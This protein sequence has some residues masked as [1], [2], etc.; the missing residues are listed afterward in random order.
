M[1]TPL[2]E[3]RAHSY[4]V[5]MAGG[6]GTRLWPLSRKAKPKQ[7]QAFTGERTMIQETFERI[8]RV[9][10]RENI[11]VS[12]TK[13]YQSMVLEQLPEM[14]EQRL[15]LEPEARNTAPAIALAAAL[16]ALIDQEAIIATIASD[17]AIE[18]PEEF[19]AVITAGLA[20][21]AKHRDTLITI[22]INPTHPDTS[23]GYIKMGEELTT[24]S[25]K[26]VFVVDAFKEKPDAKTAE[27]YLADWEYLWNAG[28]FVFSA[29]HFSR[30]TEQHSPELHQAIT[31][32][33]ARKKTNTLDVETLATLYAQT[34][35]EPIDTLI[36]EKLAPK[37][38]LVIPSA[39]RW[40]DVGSWGTLFN[41]LREKN[42][43]H[44]VTSGQHIDIGSHHIL[45]QGDKRLIATLGLRDIIIVDTPDALLVA[46]RDHVSGAMKNLIEKIKKEDHQS[47]L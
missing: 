29:D 19:T 47:L 6:S 12:T 22:G 33:I 39:L 9:V 3:K 15:L 35:N 41:F 13:N 24:V 40:S 46:H 44:T 23:L 34:P 4:A 2:S 28:Y 21:G 14:T 37:E 16:I 27:M 20:A 31:K 8:A 38:R 5:I 45:V 25:G 32:I 17:H 30:W 36:A 42:G 1:S 43:S 18:N 11:F 7:F 26:R 10:P